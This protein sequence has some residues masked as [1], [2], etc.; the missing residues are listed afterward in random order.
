MVKPELGTKRT[1]VAC[2]ARFYDL[3][4]APAVCP[5]CETE[6]PVEQPRVRRTA[7]AADVKKKKETSAA[8]TD[9]DSADIEVEDLGDDD[10]SVLEDTSDMEEGDDLEGEIEVETSSDDEET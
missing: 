4:K 2:G 6:Q 5:R 9:A 7:A 10:D 3:M 1:C 8:D